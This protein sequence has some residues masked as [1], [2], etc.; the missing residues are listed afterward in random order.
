MLW[1][2]VEAGLE[3]ECVLLLTLAGADTGDSN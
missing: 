2:S 3:K 1:S